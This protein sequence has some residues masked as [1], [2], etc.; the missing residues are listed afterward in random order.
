[1]VDVRVEVPVGIR[2][3][4][5]LAGTWA[6]FP[7][8]KKHSVYK[9]S[10]VQKLRRVFAHSGQFGGLTLVLAR[11]RLKGAF[12]KF[13]MKRPFY[14]DLGLEARSRDHAV[15]KNVKFYRILLAVAGVAML[16]GVSCLHTVF[17]NS[18]VT[19]L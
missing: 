14:K 2:V 1:M 7:D 11:W 13:C 10:R 6:F 8:F 12:I 18:D 9:K 3:C 16:D 4:L 5:A 17:S 15:Y 19:L